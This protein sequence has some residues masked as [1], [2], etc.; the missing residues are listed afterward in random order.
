MVP[1]EEHGHEYHLF[2]YSSFNI[3]HTGVPLIKNHFYI[4]ARTKSA[5]VEVSFE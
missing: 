3:V 5:A 2:F 1:S 4:R